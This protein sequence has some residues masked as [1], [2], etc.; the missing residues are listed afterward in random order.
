MRRIGIVGVPSSAGARQT[1]QERA[2]WAFRQAGLVE[3]LRSAGNPVTEYGDLPE[4]SF[5][6]DQ[7][8]PKAQN[9]ELVAEVANRLAER[10]EA[11]VRDDNLPV[12]LGGDCTI[13]LG[14]LAGMIRQAPDL[15]LLY[16]DGDLDLNTP[17]TTVSGILDG[18]VMAHILGE[19]VEALARLGPR[20]P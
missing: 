3:R 11:I 5:Q 8:R 19:G 1:G 13:T 9:L 7:Q 17:D 6:P 12:I 14:V 4:V 2:P 20:Y 15:D 16:F 18:M 10:V